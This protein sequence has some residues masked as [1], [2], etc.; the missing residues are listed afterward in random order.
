MNLVEERVDHV[1][2][3]LDLSELGRIVVLALD[4]RLANER[5]DAF[6]KQVNDGLASAN[7]TLRALF[8]GTDWGLG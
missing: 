3:D 7:M 8:I 6:L 5:G 4:D 2:L 1:G